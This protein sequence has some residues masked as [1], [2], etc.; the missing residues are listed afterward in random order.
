MG[1]SA[2]NKDLK[3]HLLNTDKD[4]HVL[5]NTVPSNCLHFPNKL[6]IIRKFCRKKINIELS[7]QLSHKYKFNAYFHKMQFRLQSFFFSYHTA[8]CNVAIIPYVNMY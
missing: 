3:S 2:S 6:C 1:N 5:N 8:L 7:K 4:F